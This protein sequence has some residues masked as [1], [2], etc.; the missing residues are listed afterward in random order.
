[1]ATVP[2]D[3]NDFAALRDA[4]VPRGV[5]TA[6]PICVERA[7]GSRVWATDGRQYL[8]FVG[9]IGVMN[10]GHTHPA[11]VEAVKRQLD[12]VLHFAFQ[13]GAYE[14]YLTLAQR[15]NK[16][17]GQGRDY[18]SVFLTTGAEAVENAVKI[19]RAYRKAPGIV[20][21]RGGFHGRTL[22]GM[23]LTGMS[24]PYKQDF[25]PFA[26]DVHHTVYPD[27][28]RG[29]DADTAL[30]ELENMFATTITPSR[31][32]AVLIEPVQ[33]DGGFLYAGSEFFLQLPQLT[34]KHDILLICDEK[35]WKR[36]V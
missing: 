12:R 18:K 8:D 16:L 4:N 6:H 10:V 27:A 32:A 7:Q 35:V 9:G 36:E 15:L 17:V 5:A 1:M 26:G 22:L 34:E 20:A 30:R 2:A 31:V 29:I 19:A 3:M 24:E 13:V 11:V 33:G 21:F 25:G 28:Y 14:G 23:T